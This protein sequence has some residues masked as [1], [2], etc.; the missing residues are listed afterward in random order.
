MV[1]FSTTTS[2]PKLK[3][4]TIRILMLSYANSWFHVVPTELDKATLCRL[5]EAYPVLIGSISKRGN[6]K[7]TEDLTSL[8]EYRYK[9]LPRVLAARR[10]CNNDKHKMYGC[11]ELEELKR[12]LEWKMYDSSLT[13]LG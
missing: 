3:A 11:L 9:E 1:P 10:D 8:D 4:L 7:Y 6:K 12:L 13:S 5:V 2:T